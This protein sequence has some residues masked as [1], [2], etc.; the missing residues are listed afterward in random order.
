MDEDVRYRRPK[1]MGPYRIVAVRSAENDGVEIVVGGPGIGRSG[2]CYWFSSE[3]ETET[4]I[5][6][7]NLSYTEAKRLGSWRKTEIPQM[8]NAASAHV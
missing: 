4:F 1:D 2:V 8:F 7:L 6:N 5:R 3:P